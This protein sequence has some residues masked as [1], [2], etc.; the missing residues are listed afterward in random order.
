MVTC[1]QGFRV[2]AGFRDEPLRHLH[3]HTEAG[4]HLGTALHCMSHTTVHSNAY[5]TCYYLTNMLARLMPHN[6]K[7]EGY[8]GGNMFTTS[9]VMEQD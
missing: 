4:H 8:Q 5:H 3:L 6:V 9:A 2:L 7:S 1:A